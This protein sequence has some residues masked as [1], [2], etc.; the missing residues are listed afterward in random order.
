[1]VQ[2]KYRVHEV[3]KDFGVN[4]K[5]IMDYIASVYPGTKNHMTTL[6]EDELN[7]VFERFT[8]EN[9]IADMDAYLAEGAA[10]REAA[11]KKP[12]AETVEAHIEKVK[13]KP[14]AVDQ[15]SAKAHSSDKKTGRTPEQSDKKR[16]DAT[17]SQKSEVQN[18]IPAQPQ[19]PKGERPRHE[20]EVRIVDISQ[21]M[22]TE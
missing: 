18:H 9:Q 12:E 4:S 1:M 5:V 16:G 10:A 22:R 20:H 8:Q 3:A 11:T 15:K 6:T 21:S 14:H 19:R 2:F 13:N 17:T 7:V